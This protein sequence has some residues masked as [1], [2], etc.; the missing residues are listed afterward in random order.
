M[1]SSL[2]SLKQWVSQ[3]L[4]DQG[5]TLQS[6]CPDASYR[7]Y[8]RVKCA[9]QTY[10]LADAS[11]ELST[12]PVFIEIAAMLKQQG[13]IVPEIYASDIKRG[14]L[15][16]ADLGDTTLLSILDANNAD[17]FYKKACEI[18]LKIQA[19]PLDSHPTL[20]RY[21]SALLQREWT[22]FTT[23][24]LE[25]YHGVTLADVA[26]MLTQCRQLFEDIFN[27]QPQVLVHRDFH[28]R[29]I[30]VLDDNEQLAVIDFQ[31]AVQ[32]PITYDAVSL[33][34]GCY[35][36]WPPEQVLEWALQLKENM[37]AQGTLPPVSDAQYLR[38]FELTGLQRHLKVLGQFCRQSLED[39]N[40]AYL[41]DMPRVLNYVLAICG[42]YPELKDLN[43]LLKGLL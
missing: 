29:N 35:I 5:V 4:S 16:E 25:K 33:L 31:G 20:P 7:R 38:W 18:I 41:P 42:R 2:Q 30:M 14:Y 15:L 32:G 11:A 40:D 21:D 34:K 37:F 28:S 24:F 13:V 26:P 12:V 39:A 6:L 10:I 3:Q 43:Q 9:G 22:V 17:S 23:W 1:A 8:F 19:Y 36:A 27:E